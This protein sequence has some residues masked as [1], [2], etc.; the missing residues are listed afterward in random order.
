M[1][2]GVKRKYSDI[3]T[4]NSRPT[5]S[6]EDKVKVEGRD[7]ELITLIIVEKGKRVKAAP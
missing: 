7:K 5:F 2:R 3:S 1:R 4:D 6:E